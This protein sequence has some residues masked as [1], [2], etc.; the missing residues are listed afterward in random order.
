MSDTGLKSHFF[1]GSDDEVLR[2]QDSWE[3]ALPIEISGTDTLTGRVR[4]YA[5]IVRAI[6]P[7]ASVSLGERWRITI[8][9]HREVAGGM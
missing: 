5:G 7:V 9:A 3:R 1:I 8:E 6:E 4:E 2:C